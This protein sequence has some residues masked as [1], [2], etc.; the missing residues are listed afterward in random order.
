MTVASLAPAPPN[1]GN[2]T[3]WDFVRLSS[4]VLANSGSREVGTH[5]EDMNLFPLVR[6]AAG[7]R[8]GTFVELGANDGRGGSLT[9][10]LE[11][12]FGWSGLLLEGHPTMCPDLMASDRNVHKRCAAVCRPG[13]VVSMSGGMNV[14]RR[15]N[16]VFAAL[17]LTTQAYRTTWHREL[18]IEHTLKV[19]CRPM[20]EL[21]AE[22]GITT[23]DLLVLDVQGAEEEVLLTTNLT[24]VKVVVVEAEHTSVEKNRRV[25]KILL[26]AGFVQVRHSQQPQKS[27]GGA[28]YN[29]L[30]AKRYLAKRPV[31]M[32]QDRESWSHN[33]P[34]G[35]QI[36]LYPSRSAG[37]SVRDSRSRLARFVDGLLAMDEMSRAVLL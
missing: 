29:E 19:D 17:E 7:G 2:M 25:R 15:A 34:T 1:Q 23:V 8:P 33:W 12:C 20:T 3:L 36:I 9:W 37:I 14:S 32:E 24:A 16:G 4:C 30:F 11:K 10:T 26:R 18:D 21:V 22:V 13:Q 6:W 27:P 28:Q 5:Y 35:E 31:K